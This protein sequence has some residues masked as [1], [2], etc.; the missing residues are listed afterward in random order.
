MELTV[1][2]Q[3]SDLIRSSNAEPAQ[4][5]P[6]HVRAFSIKLLSTWELDLIHYPLAYFQFSPCLPMLPRRSSSGWSN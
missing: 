3:S 1:S 4:N 2:L 6:R 5:P